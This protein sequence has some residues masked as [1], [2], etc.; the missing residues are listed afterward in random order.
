M[1]GKEK[2][3]HFTTSG[4]YC[5]PLNHHCEINSDISKFNQERTILFTSNPGSKSVK[6]RKDVAYESCK[7]SAFKEAKVSDVL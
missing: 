2:A 1:F 5:I 3:L 7:A 6:E 4:H